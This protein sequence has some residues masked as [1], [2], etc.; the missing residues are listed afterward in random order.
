MGRCSVQGTGGVHLEHCHHACDAGRIE[1]QRLVQRLRV[2]PR[3]K[4]GHV[5]VR[6]GARYVRA[7]C[8]GD[9]GAAGRPRI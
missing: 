4:R 6:C 1:V 2:L 9:V 8:G 7:G 3:V 5:P